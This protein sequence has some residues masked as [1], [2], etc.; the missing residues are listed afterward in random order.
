MHTAMDPEPTTQEYFIEL[1][2]RIRHEKIETNWIF[3]CNGLPSGTFLEEFH[4]TFPGQDSVIAL[5]PECGN[6][7]LRLKHKGPAFTTNAFLS[8]M[9]QIDRLGIS[10]ECFF[11]Y[12]LPGENESL[13]ND[14]IS[15][16]KLI[17]KRY[18]NVR[19][20]RNL[21]IEIEPGAPWQLE[22]ELFGIVTNRRYFRNFYQT[23]SEHDQGTFTSFGYYIPDYFD[24]PLDPER[25]YHDFATRMQAIKCRK[26]CFIHPNPKKSG[27]SWQSRLF[28][29]VASKLITLKPRNHSKP[30]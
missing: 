17:T 5:S 2:R 16:Q 11:T 29:N 30:Y 20:L 28:C 8:K 23:H 26:L 18:R 12:G 22:P 6:E 27:K 14:T 10:I 7:A 9:D 21:S 13:L 19:A 24:H 15:L 1:W 4:K 25:P 3:E